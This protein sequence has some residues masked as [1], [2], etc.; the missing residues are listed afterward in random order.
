MSHVSILIQEQEGIPG[1]VPQGMSAV[2]VRVHH[3]QEDDDGYLGLFLPQDLLNPKTDED[4]LAVCGLVAQEALS[5]GNSE[6]RSGNYAQT[7]LS[8]L[9]NSEDSAKVRIRKLGQT[10]SH[11]SFDWPGSEWT[12]DA[13]ADTA[14]AY[15][16]SKA[17]AEVAD[18][19]K[20][21]RGRYRPSKL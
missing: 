6:D 20:G 13:L 4:R 5:M 1:H 19:V 18:S 16:R 21:E 12:L 2:Y 17:L 15:L 14:N 3:E 8:D 11:A 10:K 7:L 9:V